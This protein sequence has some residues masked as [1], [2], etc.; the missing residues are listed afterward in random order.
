[1]HPR[2]YKNTFACVSTESSVLARQ[3]SWTVFVC[4]CVCVCADGTFFFTFYISR[5]DQYLVHECIVGIYNCNIKIPCLIIAFN[6][7]RLLILDLFACFM[8]LQQ[9]GGEKRFTKKRY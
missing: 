9:P 2:K 8:Y 6:S 3:L 1:M 5:I 7:L 4:V